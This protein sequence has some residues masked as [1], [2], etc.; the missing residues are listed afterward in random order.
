MRKLSFGNDV[1]A[2]SADCNRV[3]SNIKE[4]GSQL[5]GSF[6]GVGAVLVLAGAARLPRC[7]GAGFARNHL[8][9]R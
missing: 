9:F 1:V 6:S 8:P 3:G 5:S 2:T 7:A 4:K